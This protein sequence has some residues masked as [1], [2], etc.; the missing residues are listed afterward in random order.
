M[1]LRKQ[2]K[3]SFN[4][5]KFEQLTNDTINL[6]GN[7]NIF[8]NFSIIDDAASGKVLFSDEN[9]KV[10]W[11]YLSQISKNITQQSH[12]FEVGD[13]IGFENTEYSKAIA[14]GTYDGEV[15][16][17][18]SEIINSDEFI[19]TQ[20]GFITGFT[21][22][23]QGSTYFLSPDTEGLMTVDKPTVHGQVVKSVLLADSSTTGW[24]LP[25]PGYIFVSGET[26][27]FDNFINIGSGIGI[28]DSIDDTTVNLRT[29]LG[30]GDTTVSLS[31]DTLIIH[32]VGGGTGDGEAIRRIITQVNHGFQVMDVVGFSGGT[33][34]KPIADGLYDGEIL[35]IVTEVIDDDN[36]ELTL[37]GYVDV[38]S[39]V[40][41]GT[42]YFLSPDT[43]GL[44][45]DSEPTVDGQLSKAILIAESE[46]SGWVLPYV[47]YIVNSG[48]T[49][50]IVVDSELDTNS[51]NPVENQAIAT[52]INQIL[53]V[54]AEPPTYT[55]PTASLNNFNQTIEMG[56]DATAT[57]TITFN[58]NDAGAVT[59]YRLRRNGTQISTDAS[60]PINET[61]ITSTLTFQ[62]SVDYDE[63][64][65]K[66]NNLGIPDPTGKI[67]AGSV[68]TLNRT[69]TPRLRQWFGSVSEVP[70][71]S[72]EVRAIVGGQS[73]NFANTNSFN[74]TTG[75]VNNIFVIAIPSTKSLVSVID[76]GNLNVNI[77]S[78]YE[79]I[80]SSFTVL[81]A[82]GNNQT[83]KLYVMETAVPYPTSTTHVITVG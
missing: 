63:G 82:G 23:I 37:S 12:G 42:T 13:V 76:T 69:I 34:N 15:L 53:A 64:P 36:F 73:P 55:A 77:T 72:A 28:Y 62:G 3:L 31:D 14:D 60:T 33:Y 61:N 59:G 20:S 27:P 43:A 50:S 47:G 65:T 30:S 40:I 1:T 41:Q 49:A 24:V 54:I 8:G 32:S 83:Y 25:Y 10:F 22:L 9:G 29:I 35:G 21:G 18:V 44:L 48:D 38:L 81:D 5:D 17:V 6:S 75:T 78:E 58:Q 26:K 11:S 57:A 79:L 68:N 67:M 66:E 56:G 19:L 52:V 4:S 45:V 51:T 2:T 39:G 74:L 46:T 7:T 80:D 16:G 71:N 70:T